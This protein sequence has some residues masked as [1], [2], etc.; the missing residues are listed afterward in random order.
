[1]VL[2]SDPVRA[3]CRYPGTGAAAGMI[4]QRIV[5]KASIKRR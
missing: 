5:T 3:A 2:R 4:I 1:M